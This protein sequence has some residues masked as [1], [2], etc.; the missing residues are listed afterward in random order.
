MYDIVIIG[1]GVIG[2]AI[3]YELAKY[4]LD[5][6]VLE[7]ES[8]VCSGTSK[9]NSGIV[10]AGYDAK[11][12]TL[13][14]KFNVDG[15]KR[16]PILSELLA[17]DY[18][19]C[20]S[21]VLNFSEE[22]K[23]TIQKLYEQGIQNGV[24][25]LKIL[26]KEEVLSMEPNV[27]DHVV[28][29]LY[30]PSAG[31]VCPFGMTIAFAENAA[32]NGVKFIFDTPV[33][34]IEKK[35]NGF[36]INGI[37]ASKMIINAAGVKADFIHS[38]LEEPRFKIQ[39]RKGEYILLDHSAS[40][41]CSHTLFQLPSEYGKGV[42][43]TQTVHENLLVGPTAQDIDD[44]EGI[45]T[46]T[47]GLEQ[48]QEKAKIT[49]KDIPFSQTIT[50][51]AGLRARG[52]TGDFVIEESM[53]NWI[54]V[55]CI[56]SPGLTSAPSIASYVKEIV[57]DHFD[58][59]LKEPYIARRKGFVNTKTLSDSQWN[60][61]IQKDPRYGKIVCRCESI[62]EGQIVDA[63]SRSILA[64]SVDGIKRRVRAGMGRCQGGFCLPKVME[65]LVKQ[66]GLDWK[67]VHKSNPES[68]YIIQKIKEGMKDDGA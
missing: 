56:E 59:S 15:A 57:V 50:S 33:E 30:A 27:S 17:F 19:N 22:G 67:D 13:K 24:E 65:I 12:A 58:P 5:V 4:Q 64:R 6:L 8:D 46:T 66:Y 37:Y 9:A 44:K 68:G 41:L 47:D 62:S 48:I 32:D 39:A 29:A 1:A 18:K 61:L 51:F 40:H 53:D 60:D 14:A 20:G 10:H 2:C 42:L 54:D 63:C 28:S 55:A 36:L 34:T 11:P 43:I 49:I 31:I 52:N 23:E 25:G 26:S 45:D 16:I 3:A 7:K 35:E 21:L 38:L